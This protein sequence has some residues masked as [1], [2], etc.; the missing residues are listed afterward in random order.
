MALAIEGLTVN[1]EA[2]ER[3]VM[4]SFMPAVEM[5]EYL[6][7]KGVPFR[8]A[9]HIVG[10]MVKKCEEQKR[11]LWEMSV[12]DMKSFCEVFDATVF[13]YIDPNNVVKNRKTAG[14]ASLGEVEKQIETE[15]AYLS[16]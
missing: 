11:Y 5:T 12:D 14:G 16:R 7:A 9:H 3:A 10:A 13:D 15:T 8:E 6:A 4:T 1:R 2:M